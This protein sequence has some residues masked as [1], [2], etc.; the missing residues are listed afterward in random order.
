MKRAVLGLDLDGTLISCEPKQTTLLRVAACA[1]GV[2][3]DAGSVW[4]RKR[5]GSSTAEALQALHL[6][7]TVT[8]AILRVWLESIEEPQ[9][10]ALDT[11]FPEAWVGLETMRRLGW[12]LILISAR[13]SPHWV[14]HQLDRLGLKP[15]LNEVI[16]VRPEE[17]RARKCIAMQKTRCAAYVGDTESDAE[18]AKQA[19]IPFFGVTGGQRSGEFLTARSERN[20]APDLFTHVENIAAVFSS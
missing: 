20:L 14:W 16:I 10:L 11:V 13:R 9:W 3:L 17:A 15:F 1:A 18:A 12:E 8:K 6:P 5:Q 19:G 7:T 4:Q 2:A